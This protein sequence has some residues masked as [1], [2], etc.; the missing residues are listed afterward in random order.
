MHI[1]SFAHG[2]EYF[3]TFI[4]NP[5]NSELD[6]YFYLSFEDAL[7]DFL[8]HKV[9]LGATLLFPDFFCVDVWDNCKTHGYKVATYKVEDDLSILPSR[10]WSAVAESNPQVIFIFHALGIQNQLLNTELFKDFQGWV[11]EDSVHRIVEPQK[12]KLFSDRHIIID[13]IRKLTPLPGSQIFA[14]AGVLAYPQQR[15]TLQTQQDMKA[16]LKFWEEFQS[17]LSSDN[18]EEINYAYQLLNSGDNLIGD[19]LVP[20][21]L[22]QVYLDKRQLLNLSK[23][24]NTK[25]AQYIVYTKNLKTVLEND[26][27]TI[28]WNHYQQASETHACQLAFYPLIL[29]SDYAFLLKEWLLHRQIQTF[30]EFS[31]SPWAVNKNILCLPLGPHV[32]TQDIE[33]VCNDIQEWFLE[34]TQ[35]Q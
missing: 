6:S 12:I 19:S 24:K 31:D 1:T 25:E 10:F 27:L 15:L 29:K 2:S 34:R 32:N 4:Q 8:K 26:L 5:Q 11:I 18:F 20:V 28:Q 21:R 22:D 33:Q 13:S 16:A 3:S 14:N 23:I 17:L 9:S 7:W 35:L 30:V